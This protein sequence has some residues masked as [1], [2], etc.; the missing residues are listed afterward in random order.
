MKKTING[1]ILYLA[2]ISYSAVG[3]LVPTAGQARMG[4]NQPC[5]NCH[6]MHNSQN[7]AS[8]NMDGSTTSH[9]PGAA[10]LMETGCVACHT[11]VNTASSGIPYVL[12]STSGDDLAGGNFTYVAAADANGH[13]IVGIDGVDGALG[14]APGGSMTT[15]L[16]CAGT[17]GC[18]GDRL[19]ADQ[20]GAISGAH[21]GV[22]SGGA[23]MSGA[24]LNNSYRML[25]GVQ[26]IEDADWEKSTSATD[27]NQYYG[28]A[29]N[30]EGDSTTGT[31]SALCAA[32]H[33]D[34]HGDV[35][36]G[37]TMSNPWIRHPTDFD[38]DDT[39]ADSEYRSYGGAGVNAYVPGVPV[40]SSDMSDGVLSAVF[41]AGAGDVGTD[42]IV[43]CV[44][45]HRVH[46][47]EF[48]DM[49]RWQYSGMV[50]HGT[51]S[52]DNV[53]GCFAC[54]TTKDDI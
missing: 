52:N 25:L 53:A 2:L 39:A 41:G 4:E 47:S 32:C 11:G 46:A 10:L 36:A 1:R 28:V 18:H 43:T 35:N 21:H 13:N 51:A 44:S 12:D 15:Q 3:L 48:A 8:M 22:S 40:A 7:N 19:E 45:C 5:S 17:M 20:F 50:A 26:G 24:D 37:T 54:H 34:F 29:R 6:T 14:T 30:A 23:T 33:G 42:A 49:L 27:H 16:T 38:M 9:A 31:I